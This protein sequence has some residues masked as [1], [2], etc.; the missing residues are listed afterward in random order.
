MRTF[1]DTIDDTSVMLQEH[2]P[3]ACSRAYLPLLTPAF[4]STPF[5][6]LRC[7]SLRYSTVY[8]VQAGVC[9]ALRRMP[10]D[11]VYAFK[12]CER[13]H[14][15]ARCERLACIATLPRGLRCVCRRLDSG[16]ERGN[17]DTISNFCF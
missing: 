4:S 16:G 14:F 7:F 9:S 1:V 8:T 3:K 2:L 11:G 6:V 15:A 12:V 13:M 5:N 17:G 10:L